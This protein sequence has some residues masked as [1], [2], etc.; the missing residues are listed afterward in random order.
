M[1]KVFLG[2]L[3]NRLYFFIFL[4]IF[5]IKVLT[6]HFERITSIRA[7]DENAEAF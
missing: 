5:Y 4:I 6:Y 3:I 2:I 7:H 1:R